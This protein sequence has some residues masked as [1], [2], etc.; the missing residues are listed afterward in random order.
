M[1]VVISISVVVVVIPIAFGVPAAL[2]FV[3]PSVVGI[4]TALTGFVEFIPGAFGLPA[5]PAV[6]GYGLVQS[7][8]GAR[9][10]ALAIVVVGAH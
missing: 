3:P 9:Y 2:V 5:L 10:P 4:P 1:V 8:I 6:A 7:M